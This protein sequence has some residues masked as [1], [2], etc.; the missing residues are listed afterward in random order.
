M[1]KLILLISFISF[2]AKAQDITV[3]S[4]KSFTI[5]K[6]GSVTMSGD[7]SNSGTFTLNSESDEFSSIIIDGTVSGNISYNRY[8]N[9][10]GTNEWDLI[11]APVEGQSISS[12]ASANVS[13][14]A[15]NGDQFAIGTYDNETNTW[16]N[17]T[18]STIGNAGNFNIGKGQQMATISGGT[19]ILKFT[20]TPASTLQTQVIIDNNDA[21]SGA[22]TRWNLI[23]NPFP[24]Y[25]Q[26]NT[27][28]HST[29]NFLTANS[30]KLDDSYEAI[31]G[32][33][34]DGTGYT[35]YNNSS[36]ALFLAPGQG[37]MVASDN[38]SSD[39]VSFTTAMRTVVGADD[40]IT[41]INP[42]SFEL[43]LK[44]YE[45]NTEIDYTRFYFEDGLTLGLD[46]GY[47]AG[48]FNQSASLMSRL[49]DE[50]E[51]VGFAVNAMGIESVDDVI[52]PLVINREAG[53]DFRISIDT[54][55]L[56]PGTNVYIEDNQ[57]ATMTLL[58][59]QDFELTPADNLSGAGR[60]FI[61]FIE[62]SLSIEDEVTSNLLNVY[63]LNAHNF[64]TIEGLV[65]QSSQTTLRLY[66]FLGKEL[67]SKTLLN[68][69]NTQ[70]ISTQGLTSGIYVIKLES[71]NNVI[72][73]KL[74]IK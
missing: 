19:G 68:N 23:A 50:D 14:L 18:T 25:L 69:I 35:V 36:A 58:N 64:I 1:K 73:K 29:N 10:V 55:G 24:S 46:P 2:L 52:V 49:V 38:T 17:Y 8:V 11:G 74:F 71:E 30:D 41:G 51:G 21:N 66:D 26:G 63:K 44:L 33:D 57:N 7:F 20:G 32:Y 48:H 4:G 56:S 13:T 43:I 5:E 70:T 40:F 22:G 39:T 53:V 62:A 54:F 47:D 67:L 45:G 31:Y 34:A 59:E 37:F 16:T 28:A 9:S 60:F 15:T 12:F 42:S 65:N 72:T 6:T 3:A 61:H 27:N